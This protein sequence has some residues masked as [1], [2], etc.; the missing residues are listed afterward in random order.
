MNTIKCP[1]CKLVNMG[2]ARTCRRCATPLFP[3]GKAKAAGS[4][5]LNFWKLARSLAIP[6]VMI[7]L[8]FCI[9]GL[10]R[11]EHGVLTSKPLASGGN[12]VTTRNV[13]VSG[14]LEEAKKLSRD[15][16][17]RMDQNM[18]DRNGR[19]FE[20]NQK[21]AFDTLQH[22]GEQTPGLADPE[23]QK[24]LEEFSRLVERYYNQ[25][26]AYN[27]DVANFANGHQR[28]KNE[29]EQI[30]QDSSLSPEQKTIRRSDLRKE[31][32]NESEQREITSKDL[33]A[34]MLFLRTLTAGS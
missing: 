14:A 11:K 15:F 12:S 31:F 9:Y 33:D 19:G 21:L 22:M 13:P 26:T 16:V 29:I 8:A 32:F 25:L 3:E 28:M 34:T 18:S 7:A 24:H 5:G 4:R 6:M 1:E 27:S 2:N 20:L 17:A 30:Q 23:T 10:N